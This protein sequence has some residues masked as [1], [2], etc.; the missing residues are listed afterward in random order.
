VVKVCDGEC[1]HVTTRILGDTGCTKATRHIPG[2]GKIRGIADGRWNQSRWS[3]K[4]LYG[5]LSFGGESSEPYTLLLVKVVKRRKVVSGAEATKM[6]LLHPA[7]LCLC[8]VAVVSLL[9]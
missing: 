3:E 8:P 9:G 5:P 6:P 4:I 7:E 1:Q 2:R